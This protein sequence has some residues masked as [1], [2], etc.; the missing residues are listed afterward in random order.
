V[1]IV[2]DTSAITSLIQINQVHLLRRLYE[3][4]LIPVAVEK[5]LRREHSE[6]PA[7]L[8]VVSVNDA[9]LTRRFSD[10]LDAGESEAIA[11]MLEGHGDLLLIDERKGRKIAQREGIRVIGLLG[12]L[13][14]ARQI[15]LID[16]LRDTIVELEQVAGFRISKEL[17]ERLLL[18]DQSPK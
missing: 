12:V 8:E 14:A 7:F 9:V 11:I 15:G 17:K 6:L 3:R 18:E 16:S 2:S 10:Q 13:V 1:I 5:E 4:V